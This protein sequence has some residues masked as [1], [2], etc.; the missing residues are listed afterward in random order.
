MALMIEP[1]VSR[2]SQIAAFIAMDVLREARDLGRAAEKAGKPGIIHLEVGEPGAPSPVPVREAA[3]RALDA[4]RIA[5]TEALGM[6]AL[7]EAIS[8]HYKA[9]YGL[10]VPA[11]RIVIRWQVKPAGSRRL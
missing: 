3:K 7:R 9:R 6:P 4:G 1:S 5:Y 10:S 11:S 8:G 2:R